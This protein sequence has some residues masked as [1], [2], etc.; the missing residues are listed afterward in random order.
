MSL[1]TLLNFCILNRKTGVTLPC[2]WNLGL[3]LGAFPWNQVFYGVYKPSKQC[4][5]G[6]L[7]LPHPS[8][9]PRCKSF[10]SLMYPD[11]F[12]LTYQV[13]DSLPHSFH[14]T[15][16]NTFSSWLHHLPVCLTVHSGSCY[17]SSSTFSGMWKTIIEG[18]SDI[19]PTSITIALHHERVQD[20]TKKNP[21]D[22]QCLPSWLL[23]SSRMH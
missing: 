22:F 23:V 3:I 20:F 13:L 4:P 12:L 5:E 16:D 6:C 2:L 7:L 10:L 11:P 21:Y 19:S 1:L 14:F 9:C 8:T 15:S 17:L 18:M